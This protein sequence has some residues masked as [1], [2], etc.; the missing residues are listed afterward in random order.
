M[1]QSGAYEQVF[2]A[3]LAMIGTGLFSSFMTHVMASDSVVTYITKKKELI[4][5]I[6]K[7][8]RNAD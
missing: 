2:N 7:N 6:D 3:M 8:G 5:T 1:S 4:W